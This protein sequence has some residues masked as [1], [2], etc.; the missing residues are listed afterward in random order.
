MDFTVGSQTRSAGPSFR[1]LFLPKLVT[2]LHEGYG[3]NELRA[4]AFAGLTVAIVALPLSMAIAIG[5]GVS[6]ERGLYTAIV[7]G[8]LISLLGGSRFQIG[9]PAGAFIVLVALIVQSEGY[10]GLVLATIIAGLL[11]M[12]TGLLRLGTYIKY[13]PFPVTVGF[14][15][16]IAVII[17][18]A[19]VRDLLGLALSKEP[20]E[21]VPKLTALWGALPS[22]NPVAVAVS[23]LSVGTVLLVRRLRP[24]WPALLIAVLVAAAVTAGL[25]LNVETIGSLFGAIPAGLP[26]PSLPAFSLDKIRAVFPDALAIA[27]LGAI[28]SLLSAVV[29]DSMSGRRHRSNCE[30]VAQGIGNIGAAAFGGICVTG[31]LARTATN[32]RAG[33]RGPVA[34]LFHSASL[35]IFVLFAMP[36]VAFIPL[37]SLAA[38]LVVVAWSMADKAD[39]ALLLRASRAD[40]AVLLATFLLTVFFDLLTGIAVGTVLGSFVFLHRMAQTVEVNGGPKLV[41]EDQSDRGNGREKFH[42]VAGAS[43]VMVY[44]ISGAF[45]FGATAQV[46]LILDR[47]VKPPRIFIMDFSEVPFIDITAAR[48]LGIFVQ[49]L[50]RSGTKVLLTG[51]RPQL[52]RPLTHG[53]LVKPFVRYIRTIDA[54]LREAQGAGIE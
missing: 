40:A 6:P 53:G 15:A 48:A 12:A 2:V 7:G 31:T 5:S 42:G 52:R 25:Q 13:I 50:R 28:E 51:V 3:L 1:D 47:V 39:F 23:L 11:L 32:I 33:A 4:D 30:L 14:T 22:I 49:R 38:V 44:R 20:S 46:N 54:A 17:L 37:A 16:G 10:D 36:L 26:S 9:G 29:A 41:H 24:A 8:F 21:F 43:D 19:Q 18:A 35:L 45:F 27:L 34:G